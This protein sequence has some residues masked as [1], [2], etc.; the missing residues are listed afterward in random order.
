M[1]AWRKVPEELKVFIEEVMRPFACQKRI[2]FGCPAYFVN[3]NMFAGLHQESF[4]MRLSE[5]DRE[6]IK[7]H[8]DEIVPFEPMPGK[9]MK[10]YVVIPESLQGDRSFIR[11]WLQKSYD[12]TGSLPAKRKKERKGKTKE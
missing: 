5:A 8:S 2:M 1:S 11:A 12:Y 9:I 10:E 6:E 4:L 3:N 7:R